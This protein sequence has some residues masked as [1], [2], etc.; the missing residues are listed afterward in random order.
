MSRAPL[1]NLGVTSIG[2][3]CFPLLR[4]Y[5]PTV[6]APTGSCVHPLASPVLRFLASFQESVQVATQPLLPM[7]VPDVISAS[8]SPDA[9]PP[10]PTVPSSAFTCFFPD[11]N[12]LP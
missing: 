3:M 4:G 1:P 7:G 6:I 8:L 11:V 12:G 5:Y 9:W 2:E 10:N